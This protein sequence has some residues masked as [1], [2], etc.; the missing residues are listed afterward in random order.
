M[1]R[2][3]SARAEAARRELA[4]WLRSLRPSRL[5]Y[6]RMA[7]TSKQMGRPASAAALCRADKGRS[8]P[9]WKTVE[10]YVRCCGGSV[11]EAKRL[12]QRAAKAAVDARGTAV[13][14][15]RSAPALAYVLE[16]AELLQ[17]MRELRVAAG[18]PTLRTLEERAA[19]PGA[20]KVSRLPSTT[21]GDVLKGRRGCSETVLLHFVRA[22]GVTREHEVRQWT[23]AWHRVE[24]YKREG[25]ASRYTRA[26]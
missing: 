12:W 14:L 25:A 2:G 1:G 23:D 9:P 18:Q 7:Q 5:S 15:P 16:P 11:A 10:A 20:G 21:I 24:A 13:P 19:V 4:E 6:S 22:C 17:A 8:L 26:S 3:T